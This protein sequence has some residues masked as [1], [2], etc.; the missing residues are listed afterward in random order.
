MCGTLTFKEQAEGLEPQWR[1][2]MKS[3]RSRKKSEEKK[4]S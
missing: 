2:R 3:H 4:A 1:M